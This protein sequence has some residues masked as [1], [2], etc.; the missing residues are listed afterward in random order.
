MLGLLLFV[1]LEFAENDIEFMLVV[2]GEFELGVEGSTGVE[3]KESNDP[4]L[5]K[6][7]LKLL[8]NDPNEESLVG[9][10]AVSLEK[11]E[12]YVGVFIGSKEKPYE[13]FAVILLDGVVIARLFIK[14][15]HER[16]LGSN[17]LPS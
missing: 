8:S 2:G 11:V 15:T 3:V 12:S 9:T 17:L 1:E 16:T 14:G 6:S 4:V 7:E 10:K 13:E 5:K